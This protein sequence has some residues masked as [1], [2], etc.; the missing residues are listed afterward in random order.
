MVL[1]ANSESSTVARRGIL[2]RS[3]AMSG[4]ESML[5]RLMKLLELVV[6]CRNEIR[7][8]YSDSLCRKSPREVSGLI[9]L[10]ARI[11]LQ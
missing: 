11:H 2:R 4:K 3:I 7:T 6:W 5:P 10:P 8:P 1:D 9:A